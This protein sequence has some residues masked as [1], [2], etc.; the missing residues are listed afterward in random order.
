MLPCARIPTPPPP[1][2]KLAGPVRG[3]QG[4]MLD[5][6]GAREMEILHA[7]T[8]VCTIDVPGD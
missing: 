8:R 6:A 7:L 3:G 4:D 1:P 2:N 5:S